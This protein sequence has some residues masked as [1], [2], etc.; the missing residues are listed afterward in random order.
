MGGLRYLQK[1]EIDSYAN[2][3]TIAIARSKAL[4]VPVYGFTDSLT[5][6]LNGKRIE[7]YYLGA[8]HTMDNCVVWLPDEYILFA[9]C[10]C[11]DAGATGM[12]N[13][14]DGDL[15]AWPVTLDKVI[16]RFPTAKIVIPGHGHY[17]SRD[18]LWHTKELLAK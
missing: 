2:Q 6:K 13:T 11:K 8:A 1:T 12:G 3:L 15:I 16:D 7:C 14:I 18:L 4:P 5:L 10:M 9:G 17:G